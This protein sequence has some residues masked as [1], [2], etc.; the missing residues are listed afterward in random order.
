[1][2]ALLQRVKKASVSI[3][4]KK[5]SSIQEGLLLFLGISSKDTLQKID[6]LVNK[7]LH[8]RIFS[9]EEDKMNLSVLEKKYAILVVSQ[10]TLYA[11]CEKGRRPSFIEA[12]KPE[13]AFPLYEEFLKKMSQKVEVKTGKF[14]AKMEVELINDGPGTF[15]L[16]V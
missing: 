13:M 1:M 8:L 5:V 12:A 6:P 7:I 14:G 9:D 10:F 2:K 4:Q 16:E 15:L 3:E 11:N